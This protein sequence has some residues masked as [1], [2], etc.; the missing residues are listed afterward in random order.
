MKEIN[1]DRI[2]SAG[3]LIEPDGTISK[4]GKALKYS[5][6]TSGYIQIKFYINGKYERLL[7]HRVVATKYC[8]KP[9]GCNY[10]NH[11]DGNRLN[12]HPD[13]LEWLTLTGNQLHHL[14]CSSYREDKPAKAKAL[15]RLGLKAITISRIMGISRPTINKYLR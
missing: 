1:I 11:K 2:E 14:G 9:E 15:K 4:S 13:N 3:Y 6:N 10:V 5:A 7:A 8:H 12:N